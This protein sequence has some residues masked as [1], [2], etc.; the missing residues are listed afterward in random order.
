MGITSCP[1]L[2]FYWSEDKTFRV[3]GI[4]NVM[5]RDRFLLIR[6]FIYYNDNHEAKNSDDPLRKIRVLYNSILKTCFKYWTPH[7]KLVVDESMIAYN[8][9]HPLAVYM[10]RKPIRNGFKMFVL[11][12]S[13]GYVIRFFPSFGRVKDTTEKIVLELLQKDFLMNRFHVYFDK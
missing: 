13:T 1:D 5:S 4:A 3:P 12:D 9:D 2:R 8:G 7:S 11:S 10:P 6:K